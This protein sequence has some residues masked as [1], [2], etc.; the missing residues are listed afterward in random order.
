MF[1]YATE[2]YYQ[3]KIE[4]LE[5]KIQILKEKIA[6]LESENYVNKGL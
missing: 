6:Q 3:K 4:K 5:G 1:R 2:T